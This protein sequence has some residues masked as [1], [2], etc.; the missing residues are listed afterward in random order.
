MEHKD[1]LK[2]TIAARAIDYSK[3]QKPTDAQDGAVKP[4]HN[5]IQHGAAPA[6][7]VLPVKTPVKP[8]IPRDKF[9]SPMANQESIL[10]KNQPLQKSWKSKIATAIATAASLAPMKTGPEKHPMATGTQAQVAKP[11]TTE[12]APEITPMGSTVPAPQGALVRQHTSAAGPET[13]VNGKWQAQPKIQGL[14]DFMKANPGH[15]AQHESVVK[16]LGAYRKASA[17]KPTASEGYVYPQ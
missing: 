4:I 11:V 2:K 15:S 6:K 12:R 3:F 1:R 5:P 14:M 17:G 13:L 7:T 16:R 8:T 10:E 9:F